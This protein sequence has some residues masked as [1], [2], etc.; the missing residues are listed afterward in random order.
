M[1]KIIAQKEIMYIFVSETF[2]KIH[3]EQLNSQYSA[4]MNLMAATN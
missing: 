3:K 4:Q 1:A 2:S